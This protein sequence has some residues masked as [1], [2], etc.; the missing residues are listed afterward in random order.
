MK[1]PCVELVGM[2]SI[3]VVPLHTQSTAAAA[4]SLTLPHRHRVITTEHKPRLILQKG[5]SV[6]IK[7]GG[8]A[9]GKS[10]LAVHS[11]GLLCQG[12]E[13]LQEN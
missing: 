10:N 13:L 5:S 2:Q 6:I 9:I 12:I 4:I 8:C 3:V 1:L 7:G 11:K